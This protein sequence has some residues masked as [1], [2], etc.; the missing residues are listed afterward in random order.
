MSFR[1]RLWV[2]VVSAPVIGFI[3]IGGL[4]GR[5]IARD[6]TYQHLRVFEDVVSLI[7]NNYVEEVDVTRVMGGAMRGLAESLD[8]D[9]AYLTP[10]QVRQLERNEQPGTA[11]IGL[12]LTR[13]YYLRVVSARDGSPAAR[14]GLRAGDY[15]R[16][17]DGRSTRDVSA[18]EGLRLLRGAEGTSVTLTVIRGSAADPHEVSI[19]RTAISGPDVTGRLLTGGPGY[20]RIVGFGAGAATALRAQVADLVKGG[21]SALVID[22]RGTA[23]GDLDNGIAAARLFVDSGDLAI[24]AARGAERQVLSAGPGDGRFTLPVALLVDVG[25]AGAAEVFASSL[26]TARRAD[27]I[28]EK[29]LGR[30]TVQKLVKLPDGSGLW[31]SGTQYLTSAGAPIQGKGLTPTIE[32]EKPDVEFGAAAPLDDPVLD[33]AIVHLAARQAA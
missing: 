22:L 21:A 19:T 24:R 16:S 25:T 1:T 17:I 15:V 20:V 32:V 12:Q 6:D 5:A 14:A 28:G 8:S 18:F 29:T 31:I 30:A 13:Q 27:L 33:R 10:E 11:D 26:S 23:E 3:V 9:S 7:S 4:L 2:V